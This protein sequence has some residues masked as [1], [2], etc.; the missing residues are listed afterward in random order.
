[1]QSCRQTVMIQIKCP[2][3]ILCRIN[4]KANR[5][6]TGT[7]HQC[8]IAQPLHDYHDPVSQLWEATLGNPRKLTISNVANDGP[9]PGRTSG[10]K[11]GTLI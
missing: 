9:N 1:M 3:S 10:E 4:V 7:F 2:D 6:Y 11:L 5:Y 8:L